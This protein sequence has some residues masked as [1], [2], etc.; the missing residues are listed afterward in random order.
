MEKKFRKSLFLFRRDLRLE[1]NTGL[2]IVGI[3]S[4]KRRKFGSVTFFL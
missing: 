4:E 3:L 2:K 1:D